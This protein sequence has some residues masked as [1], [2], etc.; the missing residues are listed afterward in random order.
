ML[1]PDN[2]IGEPDG[3]EKKGLER[4]AQFK[5]LES[6]Y[7]LFHAT[8]PAT[9][10]YVLA[11]N[12]LA[13]LAWI[14]EKFLDWT[15][16]DLPLDDVLEAVSLYWLT[17]TFPT[18]IYPYRQLFTPGVIG[19][20][21]N[22]DWKINPTKPFG[23]SYFPMEISPTP[24]SWVATTGNLVFHRQHHSVSLSLTTQ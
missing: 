4:A 23:Y 24:R 19:A 14:G 10:G 11:S 12:P 15:D 6:A 2:P 13:L 7:A 9:I 21:E 20:H 3:F 5:R 8:K 18:S 22:P 1:K 17:G 16:K